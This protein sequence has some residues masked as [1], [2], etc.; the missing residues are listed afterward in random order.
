MANHR[1]D[2]L[3]LL[4]LLTTYPGPMKAQ[5]WS[6]GWYPGGKRASISPWGLQQAPGVPDSPG[7][8]VHSLPSD[9]LTPPEDSVPWEG[10]AVPQ[11]PLRG[12]QRLVQTLDPTPRVGWGAGQGL[13]G[14]FSPRAAESPLR[15]HSPKGLEKAAAGQRHIR[16]VSWEKGGKAGPGDCASHAAPR[17]L[18]GHGDATAACWMQ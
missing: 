5:H 7:Q 6:H 14:R 10:S 3:L 12:K 4:L 15:L 16:A 8:T 2:L 18:P 17:L 9:T 1:L 11:R 13:Q